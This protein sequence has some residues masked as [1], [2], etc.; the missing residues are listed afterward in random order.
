M[1]SEFLRQRGVY[2]FPAV[3]LSQRTG[4]TVKME[5]MPLD[6]DREQVYFVH[7]EHEIAGF[8]MR[9]EDY[10][11]VIDFYRR[12]YPG[13]GRE[14]VEIFKT[15]LDP[16]EGKWNKIEFK[17]DL[18]KISVTLNGKTE[19]FPCKGLARHTAV[20]GFGGDGTVSASGEKQYFKGKL[21][22]F[23]VIHSVEGE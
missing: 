6:I 11:R 5:L 21:K 12:Q 4:F 14:D 2:R 19:T 23:E 9:T 1:V 15:N 22:S 20:A 10:R 7:A 18:D 16:V 3:A 17:Y 13:R 8:R